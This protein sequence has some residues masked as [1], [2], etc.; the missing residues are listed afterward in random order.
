[1]PGSIVPPNASAANA[2]I[3]WSILDAGGTGA[4]WEDW[5]GGPN[6]YFTA[7]TPGFVTMEARVVGGINDGADDFVYVFQLEVLPSF[8]MTFNLN[9]GIIQGYAGD[10]VWVIPPGG[11]FMSEWGHA[12]FTAAG[13]VPTRAG[14]RFDGWFTAEGVEFTTDTVV[15]ADITITA[16]WTAVTGQQP[17]QQPPTVQPPAAQ[18]PAWFPYVPGRTGGG[19]R[20]TTGTQDVRVAQPGPVITGVQQYLDTR[21]NVIR[22]TV[23]TAYVRGTRNISITG[24]PEGIVA[25]ER[26]TIPSNGEL[27]LELSGITAGM[28]GIHPLI[29]SILAANGNVLA[30]SHFTL[31]ID[32]GA[33]QVPIPPVY[34]DELPAPPEPLLP[35]EP[36][37]PPAP[38]PAPPADVLRFTIG[39]AQYTANGMP[40]SIVDNV[41]PFVCPVYDRTMLPL[42]AVAESLGA[43]VAWDAGTRTVTIISNGVVLS[44]SVDNALPGGMG[45]PAIVNDRVFV[46]VRYV[47]EMLGANVQWDGDSRAVYIAL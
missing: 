3:T 23:D 29:I 11:S 42:R 13:L 41:A 6:R 18:P 31:I 21:T 24:L 30:Y 22:I 47:A 39:T 10:R 26:V 44:I 32:G 25:P 37:T 35:P 43:D 5:G 12:S 34:V 19:R 20:P 27:V 17:P 2:G 4:R 28:E 1:L 45:M 33:V 36:L 40:R 38:V 16:R 9:G 15:D 46:P 7:T 14:F 8:V